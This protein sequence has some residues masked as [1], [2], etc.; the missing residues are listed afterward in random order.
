MR[1]KRNQQRSKRIND[2]INISKLK[3]RKKNESLD[4]PHNVT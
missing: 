1:E 2:F 3:E 4:F